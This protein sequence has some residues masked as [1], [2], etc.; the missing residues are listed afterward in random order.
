VVARISLPK[1]RKNPTP[2]RKKMLS[3]VKL[4]P[5]R[6]VRSIQKFF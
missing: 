5:E 4:K 1:I 2:T 3:S 6:S